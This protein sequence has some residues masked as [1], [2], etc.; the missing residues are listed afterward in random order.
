MTSG[1]IPTPVSVTNRPMYS[2]AGTF[3]GGSPWDTRRQS[4]K[5][6]FA[7]SINKWPPSGIASRA[8][9][10]RL[11]SAFS[12]WFGSHRAGHRSLASLISISTPGPA[13]R[14]NN[15]SISLTNRFTSVGFGSSVWRREKASRRWV[16]AV[17][18]LTAVIAT[19]M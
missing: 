6:L 8:L 7:V 1:D 17:A 5:T 2:P 16:S 9:I 3:P 12:S 10:T 18:R 11:S 13:V 15:S 4:G 19:S 14:P